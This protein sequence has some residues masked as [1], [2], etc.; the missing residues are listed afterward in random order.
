[1]STTR[2]D[3]PEMQGGAIE[4]SSAA[5]LSPFSRAAHIPKV[6]GGGTLPPGFA[7]ENGELVHGGA[8]DGVRSARESHSDFYLGGFTKVVTEC[9]CE[10]TSGRH[11]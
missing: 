6:Y 5:V 1:M 4:I 3:H 2:P 11:L 10:P 8:K 9:L 7:W